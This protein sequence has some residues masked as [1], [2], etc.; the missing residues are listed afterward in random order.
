M[1][2]PTFEVSGS[3]I[4]FADSGTATTF[5]VTPEA[6]TFNV[7]NVA[8]YTVAVTEL[9]QLSDVNTSGVANGDVLLYDSGT[10]V[11]GTATG[12]GGTASIVLAGDVV[13]TAVAGTV[14]T[15]IADSGVAAGTYGASG[16]AVI[17][18]VA[19]DGRITAISGTA[20]SGG[21]DSLP[22]QTGNGGA[23]LGTNGTAASWVRSFTSPDGKST[24]TTYDGYAFV[25][26]QD[27]DLYSSAS[28]DSTGAEVYATDGTATAQVRANVDGSVEIEATG[29]VTVAPGDGFHVVGDFTVNGAPVSGGGGLADASR[30][31]TP[32]S[33]VNATYSDEFDD[34]SLDGAWTRVDASG[35]TG[36]ATW[37]EAGDCLSLLLAGSDSA[38]E[39]HSL[40]RPCSLGV[41]D[42]IETH[43][44]FAGKKGGT[45]PFGGLIVADGNTHGAG[46]QVICAVWT[47]DPN[48][49]WSKW[50]GYNSRSSQNLLWN[51][52]GASAYLRIKR[53]ASTTYDFYHSADGVSW[54]LAGSETYSGTPSHVG[55][56]AGSWLEASQTG[57][58]FSYFRVGS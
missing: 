41:G 35:G 28:A 37:T 20:I 7:V 26:V 12:S 24:V 21:G 10:W 54:L 53:S 14:T 32:A 47:A 38:S 19:A 45:Y 40:V 36:R 6:V 34:A 17:V 49:S 46:T 5:S 3:V 39:T 15:D 30:L 25:D 29:A 42:Y 9:D 8:G 23:V 43:V 48:L 57:F 4:A 22:T 52:M 13:G 55:F 51:L 11:A 50:A 18:T 56:T 44:S 33:G 31:W 16:T 58:S 1:T 2:S 27:G